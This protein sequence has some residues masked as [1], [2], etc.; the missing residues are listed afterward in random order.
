MMTSTLP[1]SNSNQSIQGRLKEIESRREALIALEKALKNRVN[2][3][4]QLCLREGEIIGHLPIDYPLQPREPIPQIRSRINQSSS[5]NNNNLNDN[6][7][8]ILLIKA[9][10][11]R[12]HYKQQQ[13]LETN[14]NQ[15]QYLQNTNHQA[16]SSETVGH[17]KSVPF[18]S[19][20]TSTNS[21]SSSLSTA[22]SNARSIQNQHLSLNYVPKL[23]SPAP[24]SSNQSSLDNGQ[25]YITQYN[26]QSNT[27]NMGRNQISNRHEPSLLPNHFK[28]PFNMPNAFDTDAIGFMRASSTASSSSS[29]GSA[30]SSTLSTSTVPNSKSVHCFPINLHSRSCSES[31]TSGG[32]GPMPFPSRNMQPSSLQNT[33]TRQKP[34]YSLKEGI[35]PL[36]PVRP[37]RGINHVQNGV[38]KLMNNNGHSQESLKQIAESHIEKIASLPIHKSSETL[39]V[40]FEKPL[41]N[42]NINGVEK[43]QPYYE[44]TKPFQMSDFYKYS[45]KHRQNKIN[46]VPELR[47]TTKTTKQLQEEVMNNKNNQKY[48]SCDDQ[49]LSS[50]KLI[51][52]SGQKLIQATAKAIA[53]NPSL[54]EKINNILP[55]SGDRY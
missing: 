17:N 52:K 43:F 18:P 42:F 51:E 35:P 27:S 2:E 48:S 24:S 37:P 47:T 44:E 33:I 12:Q 10:N 7:N 31:L 4:R 54:A 55:N 6:T 50:V 49:I 20:P 30:A 25:S 15:Q 19:R 23:H 29:S 3:F 46:D 41:Q 16:I 36:P 14:H 1:C 39:K 34:N 40:P 13:Q 22:S 45:S 21:T 28:R 9:N 11:L 5:S 26:D 53:V 8:S 38:T 32:A